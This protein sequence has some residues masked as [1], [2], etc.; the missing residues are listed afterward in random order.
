MDIPVALAL[1]AQ[2]IVA[3]FLAGGAY[4]GASRAGAGAWLAFTL[5]LVVYGFTMA[6][7]FR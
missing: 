7:H 4:Y 2:I 5:G 3:A 1:L 6:L